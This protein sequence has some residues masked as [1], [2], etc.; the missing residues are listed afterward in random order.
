MEW[1]PLP[2]P[3]T[4]VYTHIC[5]KPQFD[6]LMT[7]ATTIGQHMPLPLT[8]VMLL[9]LHPLLHL[10][11][12]ANVHAGRVAVMWEGSEREGE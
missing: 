12:R 10:P 2:I 4:G 9:M 6:L 3:E 11:R 1:F 7:T 8:L 5:D